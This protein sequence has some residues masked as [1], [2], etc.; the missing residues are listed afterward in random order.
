MLI[1]KWSGLS[2]L[3]VRHCK[4]I[5]S[6]NSTLDCPVWNFDGSSTDQAEGSNSDMYLKPCALF[7]DPFR[8]GDN[9][10]LM[11]DVYKYDW[12][13]AGM[14]CTLLHDWILKAL[15]YNVS[16]FK[17]LR[18]LVLHVY[19]TCYHISDHVLKKKK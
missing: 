11:C 10:L 17:H 7:K 8:K 15:V 1:L 2:N 6:L 12:R 3:E 4:C 18:C 14:L 16:S 9:K 13:T 5:F 19:L